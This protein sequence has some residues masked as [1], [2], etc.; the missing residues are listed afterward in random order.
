MS[1][2][3][4]FILLFLII[5]AAIVLLAAEDGVFALFVLP[6][7]MCFKHMAKRIDQNNEPQSQ[8]G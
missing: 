7:I 2:K 8:R 3:I 5:F 4:T 6:L 1:K